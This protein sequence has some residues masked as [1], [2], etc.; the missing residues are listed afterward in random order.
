[1]LVLL[2]LGLLMVLEYHSYRQTHDLQEQVT[3]RVDLAPLTDDAD[4]AKLKKHIETM[5]CVKHVDYISRDEAAK[6]FST[7]L[8]DDFIDFLGYNPLFPSLMVN[9]RANIL[10]ENNT[11]LIDK[12]KT[13]V[14]ALPNVENVAWQEN[15]VTELHDIYYKVS[16]FLIFFI[17]LL[18]LLSVV[19][20]SST[21]RIALYS[22]RETIRTM[23]M[24]GAKIA[25]IS[26]PFILRGLFYGFLGG[27][28]ASMLVVATVWGF[29]N[30]LSL[31]LV[32]SDHYMWYAGIAIVLVFVGMIISY[33]STLFAVRRQ[34]RRIDY[35]N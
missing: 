15:V 27:L 17:C 25:F 4:A 11:N 3:F 14:N 29:N 21:I 24:V 1:M 12:F 35:E 9:L 6:N 26:R 33:L 16:W 8:G 23:R 32:L 22:Q 2:L 10:P 31:G 5:A 18:L 28:I 34:V 19:L 7:D 30:K 13:E 20:I